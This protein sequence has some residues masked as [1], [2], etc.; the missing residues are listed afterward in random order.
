MSFICCFHRSSHFKSKSKS[1]SHNPAKTNQRVKFWTLSQNYN[2]RSATR[3]LTANWHKMPPY[4]WLK[5]VTGL[6]GLKFR[7]IF[8]FIVTRWT[9]CQ[10][11][12]PYSKVGSFV[13]RLLQNL[14]KSLLWILF[15]TSGADLNIYTFTF[16]NI[17]RTFH[18]C[19]LNFFWFAA[20]KKLTN[21]PLKIFIFLI[22]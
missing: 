19:L 9:I 5:M 12:N 16:L 4:N 22:F 13:P 2:W 8:N 1:R 10:K 17:Y 20:S 6:C 3:K 7:T 18:D 15:S 21:L 14:R 11:A